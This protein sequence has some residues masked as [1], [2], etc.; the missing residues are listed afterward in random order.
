MF[1]FVFNV[2]KVI[3]IFTTQIFIFV[4]NSL[5]SV[6]SY[7]VYNK[8]PGVWNGAKSLISVIYYD[9]YNMMEWCTSTGTKVQPWQY[10]M[11]DANGYTSTGKCAAVAIF[12]A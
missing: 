5:I 8:P 7:K 9:V 4:Y 1:L 10:S 6:M 2:Y 12:H 11:P 3:I